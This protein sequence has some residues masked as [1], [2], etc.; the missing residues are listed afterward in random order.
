MADLI[1]VHQAL[2]GYHD[3]HNLVAASVSLSPNVRHFLA[4]MTDASGAEIAQGFALAYTGLAVPQTDYY[5]LFCT[6]PAPEMPRPGCVWSHVLL[7]NLA[8]LARLRDLSMLRG[9]CQRPKT[10]SAASEYEE[11]ITLPSLDRPNQPHVPHPHNTASLLTALYRYP[12]R[13]IVVLAERSEEWE[14]TVFALW[15][16]QWPR[17]RR[18]FAFSTGSFGDRRLAGVI[19]DLQIAP[20]GS[21]RLWRRAEL[22]TTV[23][24]PTS[25][26]SSGS[27]PPW[28]RLVMDDLVA[29]SSSPL[30]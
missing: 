9:F 1:R 29:D 10:P 21:E 28:I 17:L 8:D 13:G 16:Q 25:G 7:V 2:F 24:E 11:P 4:T 23:I 20:V 22:P 14:D 30:R 3:G 12:E 5:A 6:W 18:N 19:F 26:A 27:E 15:S